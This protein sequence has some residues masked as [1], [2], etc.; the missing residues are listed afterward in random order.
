MA[1]E[2]RAFA[3]AGRVRLGLEP[4]APWMPPEALEGDPAVQDLVRGFEALARGDRTTARAVVVR[5]RSTGGRVRLLRATLMN[6]I[7]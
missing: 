3:V 4:T 1:G 7:G 2:G 6:A 5:A